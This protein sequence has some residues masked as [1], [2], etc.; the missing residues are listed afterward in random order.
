MNDWWNDPPEE[1]E[2]PPCPEGGCDGFGEV[3]TLYA[4]DGSEGDCFR[5]DVCGR[6]WPLPPEPDE[7]EPED[8]FDEKDFM[9]SFTVPER[10]PHG[11]EW[12][13]CCDCDHAGDLAY[14]AAR[15]QRRR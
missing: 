1:P 9:R 11:R 7:P 5:C 12:G 8:F 10:C 13:D 3:V 6:T 2:P 4:A 14:D 15:E